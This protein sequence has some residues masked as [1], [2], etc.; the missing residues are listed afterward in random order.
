METRRLG[1]Q[2]LAL[3]EDEESKFAEASGLLEKLS[4]V[5]LGK[6]LKYK[7]KVSL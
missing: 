1:N 4:K 6:V 5:Q 3:C 2:L 7:D